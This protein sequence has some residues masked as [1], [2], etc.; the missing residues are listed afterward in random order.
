M[1]R[2]L[3]SSVL[4]VVLSGLPIAPATMYAESPN[5]PSPEVSQALAVEG[6]R[7]PSQPF[8]LQDGTPVKLRLSQTISSADAKTGQEVPFEVM[9]DIQVNGVTVLPKG[10]TAIGVVTEAQSKRN[11]GRGGKLDMTISYARLTDGEKVALRAVKESKGGSHTGAMT[12]AMVATSLIIWPAAPFFL[13]MKGKDIS[14]PQGTE[15][16]AF[17]DG[18][19]HLDPAKFGGGGNSPAPSQNTNTLTLTPA[20]ATS[21]ET[22]VTVDSIPSGADIMVDGEFVGDTPSSIPVSLGTHEISVKKKG[23][24]TWTRKMNFGGGNIHLNAEL[25][26]G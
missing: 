19:N 5:P 23:F 26:K 17:V 10:S 12:G 21:A 15:I 11:M 1:T 25:D 22:S 13:F 7:P 9:E 14:I 3:I 8:T 18:D 20:V 16:N 6:Q 4:I 2:P 24:A